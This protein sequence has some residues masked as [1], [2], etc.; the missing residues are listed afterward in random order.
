V[1][2]NRNS[3]EKYQNEAELYNRLPALL[4]RRRNI[5]SLMPKSTAIR[6]M[7]FSFFPATASALNSPE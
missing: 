6:L 1:K 5:V 4:Y 3:G 7:G 2:L